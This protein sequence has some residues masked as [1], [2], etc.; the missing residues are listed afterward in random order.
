M[1]AHH[2]KSFRYRVDRTDVQVMLHGRIEREDGRTHCLLSNGDVRS[3]ILIE[4][5]RADLQ[6]LRDLCSEALEEWPQ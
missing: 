6:V 4:L 5:T 3:G 1:S 2:F